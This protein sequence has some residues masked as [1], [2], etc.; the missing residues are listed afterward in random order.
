V[1]RRSPR[2]VARLHAGR[3]IGVALQAQQ[4][5]VAHPQHMRIGSSMGDVAGRTA[6]DLHW[7]VFKDER[8]LLVGVASKA[9]RILRRRSP[10]LLGTHRTVRI[11]AVRA[12]HQALVDAMVKR[13]LELGLLLQMA[14]VTKRRLCLHQKKL[15][16][17]RMVRRMAGDATDI[18]LR[19]HGIDGVNML[20]ATGVT[21]HAAGVDLFRRGL[22]EYEYLG[23]VAAGH[24]VGTG[25]VAAFTTL[26]GWATLCID[27]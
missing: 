14:G 12:S 9:N 25:P 1:K 11:V 10:H 13:H 17:L 21:T 2:G 8:P 15:F 16:S 6:F 18:I 23:F 7:L 5:D 4:I 24:M 22:F 3:N 20:C 27:G 19:V 26:V